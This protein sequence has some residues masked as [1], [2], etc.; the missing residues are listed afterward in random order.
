MPRGARKDAGTT[1]LL[2]KNG[3][4]LDR[5][6]FVSLNANEPHLFLYGDDIICQRQ[7]VYHKAKVIL[8]RVREKAFTH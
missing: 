5:R 3:L 7:R 2:F 6:S 8:P 4:L 1:K